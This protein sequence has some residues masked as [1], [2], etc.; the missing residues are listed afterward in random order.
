MIAYG[1]CSASQTTLEAVALPSIHRCQ[2]NPHVEVVRDA[3]S[4]AEAYNHILGIARNLPHLDAMVLLHEDVELDNSAFER[5]V[6]RI[7]AEP[8]VAIAGAIGARHVTSLAWWEGSIFGS[9]DEVRRRIGVPSGDHQVDVIDGLLMVLSPW[10]VANLDFDERYKGFHGYDADLSFQA[11][12][13]GKRVMVTDFG[14][15]HHTKGGYGDRR[16][17]QR[18][19]LAFQLKWG[20]VPAGVAVTRWLRAET[21]MSAGSARRRLSRRSTRLT[22]NRKPGL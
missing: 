8:D 18:A 15:R 22:E 12:R 1:I 13:A 20:T 10:A 16:S 7:L 2:A 9:V 19:N 14:V 17:W 21:R 3:T 4:I 11:R 5:R 6:R